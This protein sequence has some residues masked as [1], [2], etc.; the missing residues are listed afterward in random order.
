MIL[1]Y[2]R[3]TNHNKSRHTPKMNT[4]L[5]ANYIVIKNQK[6]DLPGGAVVK[7]PPANAGDMGSSPDPGRSHMPWSN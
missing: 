7:H 4:M 2:T 3:I 5:Y 6:Q 1:Q